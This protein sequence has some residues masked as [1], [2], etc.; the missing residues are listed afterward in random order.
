MS[1][2]ITLDL[3]YFEHLLNCLAN[4]KYISEAPL[5]G[6]AIA[7]GIE[8]REELRK[9]NQGAI[10]DAWNKGMKLLLDAGRDRR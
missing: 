8:S 7:M 2:T 5:N 6:D 4:Q 10:D 9:L 3:D 1:K